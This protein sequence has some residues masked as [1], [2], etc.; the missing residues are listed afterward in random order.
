MRQAR[1]A[2][3]QIN[4]AAEG[5]LAFRRQATQCFILAARQARAEALG[6][7]CCAH[8]TMARAEKP[9]VGTQSNLGGNWCHARVCCPNPIFEPVPQADAR[10]GK[11]ASSPKMGAGGISSCRRCSRRSPPRIVRG[12]SLPS[13]DPGAIWL[14]PLPTTRRQWCVAGVVIIHH[15][16][17]PLPCESQESGF[18]W[19]PQLLEAGVNTCCGRR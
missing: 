4:P 14:L 2:K 9:L 16:H 17:S 6:L 11:P 3:D 5:T 12:S 1:G 18:S 10:R 8:E 13:M 7:R 15:A 19:I